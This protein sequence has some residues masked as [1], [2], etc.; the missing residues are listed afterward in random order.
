M[1]YGIKTGQKQRRKVLR[2]IFQGPNFTLLLCSLIF[3]W[4]TFYCQEINRSR[5]LLFSD[6]N[7]EITSLPLV[8]IKIKTGRIQAKW[9]KRGMFSKVVFLN[10]KEVI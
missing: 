4:T 8:L 9:E 10:C 6:Y 7:V 3:S 5:V 2:K 1:D